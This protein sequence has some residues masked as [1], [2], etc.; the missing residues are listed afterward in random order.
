[1]LSLL[2]TFIGTLFFLG[3][4][5]VV[6]LK[7]SP[8][9]YRLAF[10]QHTNIPWA[11]VKDVLSLDDIREKYNEAN[12]INGTIR[13][14]PSE[15]RTVKRFLIPTVFYFDL[16]EEWEWNEQE[17]VLQLTYSYTFNFLSRLSSLNVE[18]KKVIRTYGQSRFE[19]IQKKAQTLL[20][21]HRWEYNGEQTLPLTYYLAIEGESTWEELNSSVKKG[22]EAIK[23]FAQK[24]AIELLKDEFV[25]YPSINE[26]KIRWRA[27]MAV[28]R[29]IRTN[30]NTIRCRRFKGGKVLVITHKGTAEH[31]SKSWY[32]LLDSLVPYKQNYPLIQKHERTAQ[33]SKNPL[34]W[35]TKLYA[36][37]E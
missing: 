26:K 20:H 9:D 16:I 35:T 30:D 5:G 36:P 4:F 14:L 19:S 25:L 18:P 8:Q 22:Q 31:L 37:I 29:Y 33:N 7:N 10:N 13:T 3:C 28:E 2:R 23:L 32:I 11:T 24:K 34:E 15:D 12:F 27:A 1:M 6:L 17:S 21:K